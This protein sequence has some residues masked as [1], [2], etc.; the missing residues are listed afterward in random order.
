MV[1]SFAVVMPRIGIDRCE[2][3]INVV[4]LEHPPDIPKPA[5]ASDEMYDELTDPRNDAESV[6]SALA[7]NV[8]PVCLT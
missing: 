5:R 6:A 2:L 3:L 7:G 1:T 8:G 4:S